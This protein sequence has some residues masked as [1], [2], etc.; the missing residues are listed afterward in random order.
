VTLEEWFLFEGGLAG[1]V[2]QTDEG[3]SV[4]FEPLSVKR[5]ALEFSGLLAA[6]ALGAFGAS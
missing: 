2:D 1:R 4:T 3:P 6:D 5:L